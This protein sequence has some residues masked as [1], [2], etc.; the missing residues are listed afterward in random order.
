MGIVPYPFRSYA[1]PNPSMI[2]TPKTPRHGHPMLVSARKSKRPPRITHLTERYLVIAVDNKLSKVNSL[3]GVNDEQNRDA[4]KK[5][6]QMLSREH[7]RIRV[8]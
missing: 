7:S 5:L 8:V 6:K 4:W 1:H 3:T 2:M